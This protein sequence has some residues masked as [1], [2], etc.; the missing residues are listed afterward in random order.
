MGDLNQSE[1]ERSIT[2]VPDGGFGELSASVNE[3]LDGNEGERLSGE[4]IEA[5]SAA[6]LALSEVFNQKGKPEYWSL[7]K[8]SANCD[9]LTLCIRLPFS[10]LVLLHW[11]S[12]KKVWEPT[13]MV[14]GG[15]V[16]PEKISLFVEEGVPEVDSTVENVHSGVSTAVGAEVLV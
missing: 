8:D 7:N 14:G 13:Y 11:D 10:C 1:T 6:G 2:G 12:G 3:V 4:Q 5:L 16:P 9:T 15:E